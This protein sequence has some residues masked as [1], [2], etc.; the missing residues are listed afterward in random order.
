MK[1]KKMRNKTISILMAMLLC[2]SSLTGC[3]SK[4]SDKM[5]KDGNI[6]LNFWSIYPEGDANY[7]WFQKI[8]AEYEE[9]H[10]NVKINYVGISFWDYFTKI[11]TAMTDPSGPDIYI[12]TIK[13]NGDRARGQVSMNLTPFFDDAFNAGTDFFYEEDVK[14]MTYEGNV[15]GVPYAL[16]NRVLY[17]NIDIVNQLKDT[18]DADWTGTKVGQ[19]ADTTITGKPVDLIDADGN[20]RAPETYDE[21]L[22]YQELL[23]VTESGKITQLGFDVNIGNCKIENVV[24]ANGGEFFDADGNPIVTTDPGVRKGF[25]IWHELTH[26]LSSAK[27][28]AFEDTAGDNTTNLFWSGL[29]GLMIAT[30]EIPWQNDALGDAKINLGAAPVPYNNIEENHYNFTGGF[31]LEISNRLSKEDKAVQ[32]AA[33]DFVKYLCSPEVQEEVLTVTCNMPANKTVYETLQA[34]TTDPVKKVVLNEMDHRKAYDYIYDAPN[35]FGEV[36]KGLTD[37]VADKDD[38][39]ATLERI[40]KAILQ[41]KATY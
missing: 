17:Y 12:Q 29:V 5:D 37:Y 26:T 38:L 28:N 32:Q 41:L 14:P 19:K 40:Q 22:A 6:T 2:V 8:I 31:S 30:N 25:E 3:G 11:T 39:D 13:D 15:Y 21:L 35:W 36:Q 10:T 4:S 34:N 27:V 23:T 33:Y 16:D 1:K 9:E 18:T 7:D 24:F 20:V